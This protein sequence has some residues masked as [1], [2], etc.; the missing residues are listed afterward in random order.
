MTIACIVVAYVAMAYAVM[1]SSRSDFYTCPPQKNTEHKFLIETF[2]VKKAKLWSDQAVD[3][4]VY[5]PD[6][7][8]TRLGHNY[9]EP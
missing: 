4:H 9:V 1:A 8:G 2:L 5:Q 6:Q 7:K 3:A